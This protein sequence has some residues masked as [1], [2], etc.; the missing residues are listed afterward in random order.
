MRRLFAFAWVV[1]AATVQAAGLQPVAVLLPVSVGEVPDGLPLVI[2][3]RANAQLLQG[4]V[5]AF[6]ARQIAAMASRHAMNL[7]Q[8]AEPIAAR[9]AAER[10]GAEVFVYSKLTAL[11]DGYQL[12]LS[13]SQVGT[14]KTSTKTVKLPAGEAAA[15][16]QAATEL[17][18]AA[19]AV[20][21]KKPAKPSLG[22]LP[23]DAAMKDYAACAR[24]LNRQ[25]IGI[26]N[27]AVLNQ[28]E[29]TAAA[30]ACRKATKASPKFVEAWAGLSLAAAIAS[31]DEVALPSLKSARALAAAHHVPN[32]ALAR[33]WL[34]TRYRSGEAGEAVLKEALEKEPGFL[35]GRGYLGEL[36]NTLDRHADA[37]RVW[38]DYAA[39][40]PGNPFVISR[41]AYTLARLGK[42]T[43]AVAYAVKAL[44]FDPA[45]LDLNLELA[46][47]YLDAGQAEK[48]IATLEPLAA[49]KDA[50]AEV[51]LRLGYAQLVKG[52]L[53]AA[54]KLSRRAI[55]SATDPAD[56]RTRARAKLNLA[57]V[58]LKQKKTDEAKQ[59]V[60]DAV[61][62]GLHLKDSPATKELL[63]LFP[64]G[65][66]AKLEVAKPN[67]ASSLPIA[68]GEVDPSGKRAPLPK[69]FDDA[70][71]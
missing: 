43:D 40:T 4:K 56:W 48:A 15:V 17:A 22:E 33:F 25:P 53:D 69:G 2:Q 55:A 66:L 18:N 52:N 51:V 49:A 30:E 42:Q 35:L 61:K 24:L 58:L 7:E 39:V 54:E 36:Y 21:G 6:H 37:A 26:E 41:L 27:P 3:E 34:V 29:L 57:S 16:S 10:L 9:S 47:R 70:V 67:E 32:L 13:A 59:S 14:P 62:D 31:N 11:K 8:F 45:S 19:L 20:T 50:R 46:S 65:E 23:A 1:L 44:A 64:A 38:Q 68:Q 12:E 60:R 5:A 28:A 63:A 71:K